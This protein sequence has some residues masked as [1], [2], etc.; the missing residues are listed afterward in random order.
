MRAVVAQAAHVVITGGHSLV[1]TVASALHISWPPHAVSAAHDGR[2]TTVSCYQTAVMAYC[3]W[4]AEKYGDEAVSLSVSRTA[5]VT[6][7]EAERV[8][9]VLPCKRRHT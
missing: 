8:R 2:K 5:V 7:L 3:A 9:R 6:F 4:A 1:E